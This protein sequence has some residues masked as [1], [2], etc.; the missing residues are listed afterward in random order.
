MIDNG[1]D[2]GDHGQD[3]D[4]DTNCEREWGEDKN[5]GRSREDEEAQLAIL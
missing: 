1:D 2:I 4:T 3:D 5:T